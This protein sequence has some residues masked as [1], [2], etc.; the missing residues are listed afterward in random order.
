MA[1]TRQQM[2]VNSLNTRVQV[3]IRKRTAQPKDG[4]ASPVTLKFCTGP[5]RCGPEPLDGEVKLK[6]AY[7][8]VTYCHRRA[9][10]VL[11][12][13]HSGDQRQWTRRSKGAADIAA[14][15]RCTNPKEGAQSAIHYFLIR[16]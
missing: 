12:I 7:N 15:G 3:P 16:N 11:Y 10:R 5:I 14:V 6:N 9:R 2:A 8:A 4:P 13:R 1:K